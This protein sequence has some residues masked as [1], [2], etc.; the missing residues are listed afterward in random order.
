M[1][2]SFIGVI[3]SNKQIWFHQHRSCHNTEGCTTP[4]SR[5]HEAWMGDLRQSSKSAKL[6]PLMV[7]GCW[8]FLDVLT[9]LSIAIIDGNLN[10]SRPCFKVIYVN[11]T[12]ILTYSYSIHLYPLH[13]FLMILRLSWH[14]KDRSDLRR[15]IPEQRMGSQWLPSGGCCT[16][17]CPNAAEVMAWTV[18][19][20]GFQPSNNFTCTWHG[21]PDLEL[22]KT[23]VEITY[24]NGE[25]NIRW[26]RLCL[27]CPWLIHYKLL[28]SW[29][30][31]KDQLWK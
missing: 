15:H 21:N 26:M 10:E 17:L 13:L 7:E 8:W 23:C 3:I 5:G 11:S 22:N 28:R 6:E 1:I 20:A 14:W 19:V 12:M 29:P 9:C 27:A 24:R 18:P 4:W 2:Y 31:F 16:N 30:L 25:K